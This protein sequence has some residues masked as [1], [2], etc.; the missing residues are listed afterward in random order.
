M[1]L[2]SFLFTLMLIMMV[3]CGSNNS[4]TQDQSSSGSTNN[5]KNTSNNIEVNGTKSLV[6]LSGSSVTLTQNG[7]A[8]TVDILVL[9][10]DNAPAESGTVKIAYP[11]K[12][13]SGVDIGYFNTNSVDVV[14][15]HAT[16]SYVGPQN[17]AER[18]AAGDTSTQFGFYLV[19]QPQNVSLLTF[20][21]SPTPNQIILTSY[22][23]GWNKEVSETSMGIES[24]TKL[25][26]YIE[27]DK[28]EK[29]K[30]SA[31]TSITIS[32]ENKI[33]TL[34]DSTGNTGTTLTFSG[35]NNVSVTIASNTISGLVPIRVD[36]TFL[37]ANGKPQTLTKVFNMTI[38]SGPP[39]AMSI[40]YLGTYQDDDNAKFVD[41]MIV[42]VTD[43]YFNQV[44]TQPAIATAVIAGYERNA[45][46]NARMHSAILDANVTISKDSENR[47]II[48][49]TNN[50]VNFSDAKK[51]AVAD[52]VATFANG[53]SYQGSGKW[54][55]DF[56]QTG[57]ADNQIR[58]ID[59]VNLS[60]VSPTPAP[61]PVFGF[62]VGRNYRQDT[63]RRGREWVGYTKVNNPE[64]NVLTKEGYAE[65][66]I[67]YD[68]YLVGKNVVLTVNILGKDVNLI[69]NNPDKFPE[70]NN[71]KVMTKIG[72]SVTHLLRGNGLEASSVTIPAGFDGNVTIPI[73]IANTGE[74]YR[75]ANFGYDVVPSDKVVVNQVRYVSN[76]GQCELAKGAGE[77][78]AFVELDVNNTGTETGS[79]KLANLITGYEF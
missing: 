57:M 72:E 52:I 64:G 2:K 7:Q 66:D 77:G 21:Y 38:L 67:Y 58:L 18:V 76:I 34:Q 31:V 51:W 61:L 65:I 40:S 43:K 63:C 8:Y 71:S 60:S 46:T 74:W 44:N 59:D 13:K 33:A 25:S 42:T 37:D 62:A 27:N 4:D 79:V 48:T 20:N 11:E 49:A 75:N 39:T 68:Y 23:L 14:N 17:L 36:A 78:V 69:V 3:G 50:D 24:T 22:D 16:F 56:N 6:F 55:I 47:T 54:D 10:P 32:L 1:F 28:Q 9:G 19:D 30:D 15:G 41:K 35:K 53:Y 70:D 29:I 26:F 73:K 12:I 5:D 45:T